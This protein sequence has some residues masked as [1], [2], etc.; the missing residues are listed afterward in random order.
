MEQRFEVRKQELLAECE[1][2]PEVFEGM[3]ERLAT[4]SIPYAECLWRSEQKQHAQTYLGGLLSDLKRKNAESIA[5]RHD[6]DRQGLQRFVGYSSWDH[7]PLLAVMR[8]QVRAELG[9]AD[10]VL[11]FDPSAFPKKGTKSVAVSRQWCGRLGKVDN[12][13]VGVYLGYVS[14]QEHALVALR[15]YLPKEWANDQTRREDGGVPNEIR[16]RTRQELALEMLDETGAELPHRWV[17]GDDEMGRSAS[18]RRQL[19]NR[20]EQYLL[21]V[22]SNTNV[23][24]LGSPPPPW[25][26]RGAK[27]KQPFERVDRWR[28]RCSPSAWTT[29]DV[30]DGEK[31]PLVVE[32]VKTRVVARTER[33]RT[34]AVEEVLVV[35]RTADAEGQTKHDYYLSN[36]APET[37][38]AEFVRVAKAE[39]RIEE[40][41][42][43][44]KSEAGLAD[45]E[46]RTW[47][48]WHHHQTLSLLATWFLT[49]EARRGEKN[50]A[51]DHGPADPRRPRAAPA[52]S[53]RLWTAGPH[54]S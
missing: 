27:P 41:L 48:G 9:E 14:R 36:A 50:H 51:G 29:V 30:R 17:A 10:G 21:A 46:V 4:F 3:M 5:Y 52:R 2:G 42:E 28:A 1:V 7:R 31:G 32:V 34:G 54:C 40:C 15:L 26:G 38:L 6:Q 20:Q 53:V 43:R 8:S 35:T 45:Y 23:R 47:A 19:R 16:Y 33:S 11:V 13:Q 37:P 44:A 22:P 39:H 12:C 49:R 24:D 25:K 18:F